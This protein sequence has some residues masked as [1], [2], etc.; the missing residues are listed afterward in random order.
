MR[1]FWSALAFAVSRRR[2]CVRVP[3][4]SPKGTA[5][6]GTGENRQYKG[7]RRLWRSF[8]NPFPGSDPGEMR[9]FRVDLRIVQKSSCFSRLNGGG[10]SHGRTALLGPVLNSLITGKSAGICVI[11][12]PRVS[13]L[14]A[15]TTTLGG[16]YPSWGLFIHANRTGNKI[17]LSGKL[18]ES[19]RDFIHSAPRESPMI[20]CAKR[21]S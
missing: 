9:A 15:I 17:G 5:L 3:L 11:I 2:V 10:C 20:P 8:S 6:P 18:I 13:R 16:V 19:N 1:D 12:R 21:K 14:S 4:R 7:S